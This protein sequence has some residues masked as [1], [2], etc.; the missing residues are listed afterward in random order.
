MGGRKNL[1]VDCYSS[2]LLNFASN[3]YHAKLVNISLGGAL[4]NV[5]NDVLNE[6][7]I[8]D[9]CRLLLSDKPDLCLAKSCRVVSQNSSNIGVNF[10]G[11]TL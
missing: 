7:N 8:G 4:I 5:E 9:E 11:N 3:N 6:L 1:R 2:C 10:S